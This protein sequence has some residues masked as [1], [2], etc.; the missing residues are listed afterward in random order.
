MFLALTVTLLFSVWAVVMKLCYFVIVITP[1]L[2]G[3]WTC[4][5]GHSE[6]SSSQVTLPLRKL[7]QFPQFLFQSLIRCCK[8]SCMVLLL[9][10]STSCSSC[11]YFYGQYKIPPC[12]CTSFE[13][14]LF[15]LHQ[16]AR[17]LMNLV[18]SKFAWPR[19]CKTVMKWAVVCFPCR[20]AKVH[21]LKE[22]SFE[23]SP[24]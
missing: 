6:S 10:S 11:N 5:R 24:F 1:P 21:R 13:S 2:C 17:A 12:D 22:A 18:S 9:D 7:H 15:L 20:C 23:L 19:R 16:G 4:S 3:E 14:L 8:S